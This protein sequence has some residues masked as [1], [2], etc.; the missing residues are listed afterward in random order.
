MNSGWRRTGPGLWRWFSE[1]WG[2]GEQQDGR[3]VRTL[4]RRHTADGRDRGWRGGV[5]TGYTANNKQHQGLFTGPKASWHFLDTALLL[6]TLCL[7][8]RKKYVQDSYWEC[9]WPGLTPVS[10]QH[11]SNA[12]WP[13]TTPRGTVLMTAV[14]QGSDL[15][16]GSIWFSSW[17]SYY[18]FPT[19]FPN[20][21]F[22]RSPVL[23][24]KQV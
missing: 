24:A 8:T 13:V 18:P 11:W 6:N 15:C 17:C 19:A 4:G 9:F 5:C 21:Y 7:Q 20:G 1:P 14:C 2:S 3:H 12:S 16:P 23:G 10:R 22:G